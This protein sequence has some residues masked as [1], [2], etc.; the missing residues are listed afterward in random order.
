M[1]STLFH[2]LSHF[3]FDLAL[4]SISHY[5][6]QLT[7]FAQYPYFTYLLSFLVRIIDH[8]NSAKHVN[9]NKVQHF[10]VFIAKKIRDDERQQNSFKVENNTST[11]VFI[12]S[13]QIRLII[14]YSPAIKFF[15]ILFYN[16]RNYARKKGAPPV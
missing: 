6:E 4:T 8:E 2:L 11:S 16:I 15:L 1:P 3:F 14:Y 7:H 12:V 5:I 10:N 9:N 13:T